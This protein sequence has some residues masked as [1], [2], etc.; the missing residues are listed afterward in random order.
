[1]SVIRESGCQVTS[2]REGVPQTLGTVRAWTHV[3]CRSGA[4]AISFRT[5]EFA[6]G[7]APCLAA[8]GSCEEVLFVLSGRAECSLGEGVF[9]LEPDMGVYRRADAPLLIN[10]HGSEP[11]V[12]LSVRCPDPGIGLEIGNN[13]PSIQQAAHHPPIVRMDDQAVRSAPGDRW[14]R[15]LIDEQAGS[16]QITQ[17]M[18]SVPPGRA[19]EHYHEYEEVLCILEGEGRMW[20][21]AASASAPVGTCIFLPRKQIH[22]LENIG[23]G[24]L[25]LVGMFYPAG[26][27][28][29]S[30]SS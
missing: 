17:F 29:V 19:P 10:T 28:T 7:R 13:T 2:L 4:T 12:L 26:D 22:A 25:R 21:G 16:K 18:G 6:P 27:P 14:Y 15:L 5:L 11:L 9:A 23:E 1:M 8:C 30:Y 24:G 3:D 20:A